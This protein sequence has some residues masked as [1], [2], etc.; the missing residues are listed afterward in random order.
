MLLYYL[1]IEFED[2]Q[3]TQAKWPLFRASTPFS[4]MPVYKEE[5]IEIPETYA[6]LSYLGRKHGLMG[7]HKRDL[8]S[9][10]VTMEAWRDYGNRVANTFGALS[11]SNEA[12]VRFLSE[13]QPTLLADLQSFYLNGDGEHQF[14]AG[15]FITVCD[16]AAFHLI[17]GVAAQFLSVLEDYPALSAFYQSLKDIPAIR[18]YLESPSRPSALFYGPHGK[19]YPRK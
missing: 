8:I 14:W 16:F 18:H 2:R 1:G 12:R 4:R 6:I 15:Q 7:K 17:D 19:I 3:V 5:D 10:D 13:E 11:T 9:C